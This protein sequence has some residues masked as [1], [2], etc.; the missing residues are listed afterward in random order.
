MKRAVLTFLIG[1]LALTLHAA[2]EEDQPYV[3]ILTSSSFTEP[4]LNQLSTYIEAQIKEE[5]PNTI[6]IREELAIP[7]INEEAEAEALRQRLRKQYPTSP[8]MSFIFGDPGYIV[9]SPLF[10]E[11]W[12]GTP[13]IVYDSTARIPI[14]NEVL[15]SK[16][17][18]DQSNSIPSEEFYQRENVL[19][20]NSPVY[21]KE[22]IEL[23][24]NII[25]DMRS[26]QLITD[27]RYISADI[28]RIADLTI[29]E[30]FPEIT[31]E[32][33]CSNQIDTETLLGTINQSDEQT[34]IIYY[35]WH[36]I[37]SKEY[38][39]IKDNI[40]KI[41][42]AFSNTPVFTLRQSDDKWNNTCGGYYAPLKEEAHT[43]YGVIRKILNGE[44]LK[45]P[46]ILTIKQANAYL[47]YA[48][49]TW[50]NINPKLFPQKGVIYLEIPPSFYEEH[51]DTIWMG[52]A[53][54]SLL[55]IFHF[56][57][58]RRTSIH[59]KEKLQLEENKRIKEEQIRREMEELNKRYQ[60]V[61][62]TINLSTWSMIVETEMVTF[63][64]HADNS[65]LPYQSRHSQCL[66]QV[67]AEDQERVEKAVQALINGEHEIYHEQYRVR[68]DNT[69]G[70]Y[71]E[72]SFAIANQRDPIT[73]KAITIVGGT[74]YI[75]ERKEIEENIIR[76]KEKAEESDRLKSAFL[77]NMSHEI[78]TPLN[79]IIG[80]SSILAD[81]EVES[82][83]ERK[84]YSEYIK[85]NN[86][87]LLQL[88]NDILDLSKIEAGTLEFTHSQ[89]DINEL[90]LQ[91][92]QGFDL[93]IKNPNL[94][95]ILSEQPEKC[96]ITTERNRLTQVIS[97]FLTNAI[98]FTS[99]G[100]IT[101]GYKVEGA[102]KQSLYFYVTDTGCGIPE[103][104]L[105]GV[106]DRFVKLDQLS[107]GTGLGL[108]IC[109]NIIKK[110]NGEIGVVSEEGKG[111]T[112]WFRIPRI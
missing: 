96:I 19:R 30:H 44:P 45:G 83:E 72:E 2:G 76:A 111:S 24:Q 48:S 81:N 69:K 52:I 10:E 6:I 28:R 41:I 68:T 101:M 107:R 60:L 92:K 55:L 33:L 21:I 73:R 20:I 47:N 36:N 59:Q 12:Q 34:G 67:I 105:S 99:E 51:W 74:M 94:Q 80:F 11:E 7:L 100:S 106:F 4:W 64:I 39:Y 90:M 104:S 75:D 79:S 1:I 27:H 58:L 5:F 93:K 63:E 109:K 53:C 71:W 17:G 46:H 110:L 84:K 89:V 86:D 70:Y 66:N 61:I 32:H 26:L 77:A 16:I 37:Q 57:Y 29:A 88:I 42:G 82:D 95:L 35:S 97:N 18:L 22:T 23:M 38:F 102:N 13:C 56:Y 62:N 15:F 50:Y 108:A 91:I 49:L 65:A 54:I 87:L 9:C 25:P 8:Q 78:R 31:L 40:Q 98:K 85:K 14:S 103:E 3:L 43:I 112:F